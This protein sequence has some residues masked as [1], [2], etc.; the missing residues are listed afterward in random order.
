M[1]RTHPNLLAGRYRIGP[2]IGR[3]GMADV[4]QAHDELLGRDVA[5]KVFRLAPS[6]PKHDLRYR[7]EIRTLAA[8]SHP[9]LVTIFDAGADGSSD[10]AY[11]VMELIRG[12]SLDRFLD[13]GLMTAE[14]VAH[15]G[16][17][18]GAA[19][20]YVHDH[21]IVH[22]D[23]KPANVLMGE[24]PRGRTP[25]KL[26]DFGIARILDESRIT[27]DD[28][29]VG[30]AN[31]LSPEQ[32]TG[33]TVG[34]ASDIYSLGLVLLECLTGQEAYSGHGVAAAA[35]RLHRQ[36]EVPAGL[37]PAWRALL[38][39]M[40]SREPAQ[41]PTAAQV[42]S[43]LR[44]IEAAP[45]ATTAF[46]S[47]A[48]M[49]TA[50]LPELAGAAAAPTVRRRWAIIATAVAVAVIGVLSAV[51][52]VALG[53]STP[54]VARTG[55]TTPSR[56]VYR[57]A[58]TESSRSS[59][60]PATTA[61]HSPA[62]PANAAQA[63]SLVRAALARAVV[64]GNLDPSAAQDLNNRLDDLAKSVA[65]TGGTAQ[66]AG[67]KASDFVQQ[68]GNLVNNGQL[69]AAGMQMLQPAVAQVEQFIPPQ[70]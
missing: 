13:S 27:A 15:V 47:P 33:S 44:Q 48:P 9:N 54:G 6:V 55:A 26:S 5:I 22:R 63:I 19:L 31:Y 69:S 36:P 57:P 62:P 25:V 56:S 34:P 16:E 68:L 14:E 3:G 42:A 2:V 43:A 4:H 23:L 70:H 7:R 11:L 41:R 59:T 67:H 35:A 8:L 32:A 18:L 51:L 46:P 61:A 64:D 66:D 29:T 53:S 20:Q 21:G 28:S 37:D 24:G 49:P 58:A 65:Q 38:T 1:D 10:S 39:A 40:T 52:L 45:T 30:T 12:A 50:V 60:A 17:Q